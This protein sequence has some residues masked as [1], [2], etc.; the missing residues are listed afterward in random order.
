MNVTLAGP[1]FILDLEFGL[2]EGLGLPGLEHGIQCQ[3]NGSEFRHP[4]LVLSSGV[5]ML[6]A[7]FIMSVSVEMLI[8]DRSAKRKTDPIA[9]FQLD[10]NLINVGQYI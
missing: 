4:S 5:S 8:L 6:N 2:I 3:L 7:A 9:A 1:I 10:R